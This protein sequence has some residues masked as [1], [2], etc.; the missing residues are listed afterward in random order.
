MPIPVARFRVYSVVRLSLFVLFALTLTTAEGA[1]DK[2]TSLADIFV[3]SHANEEA[4]S[5]KQHNL[6]ACIGDSGEDEEEEGVEESP[7][8]AQLYTCNEEGTVHRSKCFDLHCVKCTP[9]L[10]DA[11]WVTNGYGQ[12][13]ELHCKDHAYK[14]KCS[15]RTVPHVLSGGFFESLS[16]TDRHDLSSHQDDLHQDEV[17]ARAEL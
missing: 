15:R 10:K 6:G 16:H 4:C 9:P 7:Y 8:K 13:H 17:P 14:A 2:M 5:G 12:F 11:S 3:Y 1:D